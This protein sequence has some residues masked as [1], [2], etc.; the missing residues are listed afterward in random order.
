MGVG[1]PKNRGG[2]QE[3]TA[4]SP[5]FLTAP[6]EIA[7]CRGKKRDVYETDQMASRIRYVHLKP[8]FADTVIVDCP[9]CAHCGAL[10]VQHARGTVRATVA[11]SLDCPPCAHC[12]AL[13]IRHAGGLFG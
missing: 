10:Q 11:Q 7:L 6:Q 3:F 9:P 2:N 5:I 8:R 1:L 4:D 12:G 13:Q